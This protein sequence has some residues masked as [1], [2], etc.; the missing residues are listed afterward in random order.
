MKD[1]E[2]EEKE[3]SV[4]KGNQSIG[5]AVDKREAPR[6]GTRDSKESLNSWW[7]FSRKELRLDD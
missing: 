4:G 6:P 3:M 2:Q 5:F 1:D 7:G